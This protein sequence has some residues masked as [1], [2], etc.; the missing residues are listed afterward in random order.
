MASIVLCHL[1]QA[2]DNRNYAYL[3]NKKPYETDRNANILSM[4]ASST[5]NNAILTNYKQNAYL[6]AN[7]LLLEHSTSGGSKAQILNKGYNYD[8]NANEMIMQSASSGNTVK[9]VNRYTDGSVDNAIKM[10]RVNS[11]GQYAPTMQIYSKDDLKLASDGAVRITTGGSQDVEIS[12]DD[13]IHLNYSD[14]LYFNNYVITIEN[15]YVRAT[16]S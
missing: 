10:G 9:I 5:S 12:A 13:D 14:K 3:Q 2:Y 6:E 1:L 7:S 11:S 16:A 15:G 8:G 4:T